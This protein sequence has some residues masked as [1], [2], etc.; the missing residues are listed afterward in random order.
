[1]KKSSKTTTSEESSVS[2]ILTIVPPPDAKL[3]VTL[4]ALS[5][6]SK[7]LNLSASIS[8]FNLSMSSLLEFTLKFKNMDNPDNR[9]IKNIS[10]KRRLPGKENEYKLA[11]LNLLDAIYEGDHSQNI[12]LYDGDVIEIKPASKLEQDVVAVTENNLSK[13]FL[14]SDG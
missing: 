7:A 14:L 9:R 5:L 4:S 8:A 11:N 3:L 13:N 1:M 2:N 6:S 12:L 10:I